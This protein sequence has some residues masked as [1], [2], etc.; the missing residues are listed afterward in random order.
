MRLDHPRIAGANPSDGSQIS[1]GF[2]VEHRRRENADGVIRDLQAAMRQ[3]IVEQFHRQLQLA[4]QRVVLSQSRAR[5]WPPLP[6][7]APATIDSPGA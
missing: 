4:A 1:T 3:V 5:S 6:R 7:A 2:M